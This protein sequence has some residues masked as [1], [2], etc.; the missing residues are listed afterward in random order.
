MRD[1][2]I[3]FLRFFF[4]AVRFS[5]F[6]K[7]WC[8]SITKLPKDVRNIINNE[9]FLENC[10]FNR[11]LWKQSN[12]AIERI[13]GD[14]AG[15]QPEIRK[16]VKLGH[17]NKNFVKN[18]IKESPVGKISEFFLHLNDKFNLRMDTIRT[19]FSKIRA[20]F[21]I[22]KK[23]QGR[24]PLPAPPLPPLP[25]LIVRLIMEVPR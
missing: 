25:I 6:Y 15:A 3:S 7:E 12:W 23:G 1:R 16:F 14:N 24:P 9:V 19:F 8:R 17:F 21:L 2:N 18:S 5:R 11:Q 10:I 20:I 13:I 22:F 4:R